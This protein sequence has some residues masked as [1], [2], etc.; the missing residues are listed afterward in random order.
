MSLANYT[1]RWGRVHDKP[2]KGNGKYPSNNGWL[3]SAV[4]KRL[5]TSIMVH[6]SGARFCALFRVR[7]P[8]QEA[9]PISRDEILA[10]AYLG[11]LYPNYLDGWNFSPFPIPKFKLFDTLRQAFSLVD[12]KT[13]TLKHRN[14]FWKEGYSQLYRFAFSVPFQDRHFLNQ[15]WG[16]YNP[17]WHLIH[18]IAHRK[19]PE[20]RSSRLLRYLKTGQ[21]K[22]AVANYFGSQ[23]PLSN[24]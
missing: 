17:F 13:R 16:K 5:G 14:T 1:D 24:L 10:L 18:V 11:Y 6:A 4:A 22:E 7:H 3:Y 23:H 9:P 19:K 8:D 2:I 20:D 21:D 15:C 12:W